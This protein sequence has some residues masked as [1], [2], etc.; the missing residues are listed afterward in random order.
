MFFSSVNFYLAQDKVI[1]PVPRKRVDPL[2]TLIITPTII[3]EKNITEENVNIS[4][5]NLTKQPIVT[6]SQINTTDSDTEENIT[7]VPG[8]TNMPAAEEKT[9]SPLYQEMTLI[10]SQLTEKNNPSLSAEVSSLLSTAENALAQNNT[11]LAQSMISHAKQRLEEKE[12]TPS[13][14]SS[15]VIY[16]LIFLVILSL[17]GFGIFVHKKLKSKDEPEEKDEMIRIGEVDSK[18]DEKTDELPQK[19]R[20]FDEDAVID[21]TTN[22][23]KAKP[24]VETLASEESL[25]KTKSWILDRLKEKRTEREI[26]E[27]LL[28]QE[29]SLAQSAQLIE[30][31]KK[32]LSMQ[33][34][35]CSTVL[36]QGWQICPSCG[37]KITTCPICKFGVY[38]WWKTCPHCRHLLENN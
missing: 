27:M 13:S 8:T 26:E 38:S 32:Q 9:V 29:Y 37:Q 5:T 20:D 36:E 18:S 23:I 11:Q 19:D 35:Q 14:F 6:S 21:T 28:A 31:M 12:E 22:T 4:T 15:Y 30:D 7:S 33:C 25:K 10:K 3:V 16:G 24:L 34:S 17:A 1:T 2:P